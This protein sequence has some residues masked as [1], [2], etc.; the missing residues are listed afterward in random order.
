VP[1]EGEELCG[2]LDWHEREKLPPPVSPPRKRSPPHSGRLFREPEAQE[3]SGS[4]YTAWI[5]GASRGNPGPAAYAVIVRASDGRTLAE[6]AKAIGRA[7]NNVAEYYALIAALDYAANHGI[8]RLRIESDSE[9]LV[10]QL[11]GRYKVRSHDLRPLHERAMRLARSLEAFSIRHVPRE[12]NRAADRLANAALDR[13]AGGR[14]PAGRKTVRARYR[15]GVLEPVEP[16]D[17]P[18]GAEVE[19]TIREPTGR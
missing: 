12:Q 17:L 11:E 16:L 10:R 15:G 3:P 19:I 2:S 5:D 9:L 6:F 13:A 1:F 18:E 4:A 7:S 14:A 8:A